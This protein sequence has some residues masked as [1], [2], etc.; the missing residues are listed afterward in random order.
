MDKYANVIYNSGYLY[1]E[2]NF[3][4]T[5][6]MLKHFIKKYIHKVFIFF[7]YKKSTLFISFKEG[8]Q[9]KINN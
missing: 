6:Q 9:G 7:Y 5:L 4:F 3:N 1:H 2:T 8:G